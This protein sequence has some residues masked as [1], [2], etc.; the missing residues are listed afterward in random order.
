VTH[1]DTEA[2]INID[3]GELR[4]ECSILASEGGLLVAV[5]DSL[6]G[7]NEAAR[8]VTLFFQAAG[9]R[10][11]RVLDAGDQPSTLRYL[12]NDIV[13]WARIEA[14]GEDAGLSLAASNA[15]ISDH[16]LFTYCVDALRPLMG[17]RP[18]KFA[19]IVTSI[20]QNSPPNS[21]DLV[22][23]RRLWESAG[24][25]WV[26]IGDDSTAW[27]NLSERKVGL[28]RFTRQDLAN[29]VREIVLEKGGNLDRIP[30]YLD[31][32]FGPPANEIIPIIAYA[33]I[34]RLVLAPVQDYNDL[35]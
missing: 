23:L 3:R 26:A 8:I 6:S 4:D 17:M 31:K 7:R 9:L 18:P 24:G 21:S 25:C 15:S 28:R 35:L 13:R 34:Q 11:H 16:K 29:I 14:G 20:G 2:W 32:F 33:Q 5:G 30:S 19:I 1:L 10:T 12:L 22:H 27:R